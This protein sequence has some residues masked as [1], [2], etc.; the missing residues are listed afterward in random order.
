MKVLQSGTFARAV[1]K[2]QPNEK[3]ALDRAVKKRLSKPLT[4]KLK[5]GDL[6]GVRVY[7]FKV[8]TQQY[9]LG[10]RY[11]Q[12]EAVLTLLALVPMKSSIRI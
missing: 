3:R 5:V 6:A 8:A 9:L 12:E 11:D 10:Y 7:K 4:G 2:V 1:R